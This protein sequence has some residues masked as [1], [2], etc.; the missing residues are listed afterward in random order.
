MGAYVMWTVVGVLAL[1]GFVLLLFV[2]GVG[3]IAGLA[4]AAAIVFGIVLGIGRG[5][6]GAT[7]QR[8]DIEERR[9]EHVE[10]QRGRRRAR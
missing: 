4:L 5:G 9:A 7:G 6:A 2:P 10:R 1:T 3:L 8:S